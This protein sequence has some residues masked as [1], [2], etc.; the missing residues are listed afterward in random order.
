MSVWV[1]GE[2]GE[3]MRMERQKMGKAEDEI[4]IGEGEIV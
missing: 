2:D 1:E 4:E 3:S